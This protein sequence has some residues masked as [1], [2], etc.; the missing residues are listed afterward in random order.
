MAD[1]QTASA[2]W[3]SIVTQTPEHGSIVVTPSSITALDDRNT[4]TGNNNNSKNESASHVGKRLSGSIKDV[5]IQAVP[6]AGYVFAGWKNIEKDK[7]VSNSVTC[8]VRETEVA[9]YMPVFTE[10]NYQEINV[11]GSHS[12]VNSNPS[13]IRA[14]SEMLPP[15]SNDGPAWY[16]FDKSNGNP[17]TTTLWHE[18]YRDSAAAA[19]GT[20]AGSSSVWVEV[21]LSGNQKVKRVTVTPRSG[22]NY[23][24]RPKDYKILVANTTAETPADSD[25]VVAA[26]GTFADNTNEKTI[27]LPVAVQPSH[28]RIAI[29]SLYKYNNNYMAIANIGLYE[30][31]AD[32]STGA[33][34]IAIQAPTVNDVDM[35]SVSISKDKLLEGIDTDV[36][37]TATPKA[38]YRFVKWIVNDQ[39]GKGVSEITDATAT[40]TMN[41]KDDASY[42]AIF[43]KD[44]EVSISLDSTYLEMT[45]KNEGTVSQTLTATLGNAGENTAVTWESSNQQVATVANGVVTAVGEGEAT[46]TATAAADTT[47]SATCTVV[48]HAAPSLETLKALLAQADTA[49]DAVTSYSAESRES[50]RTKKDSIEA[51][52]PSEQDAIT[53]A[54]EELRTALEGLVEIYKISVPNDDNIVLD[55]DEK[56]DV[57]SNATSDNTSKWIYTPLFAKVSLSVKNAMTDSGV[58]AGWVYE[59]KTVSTSTSYKFYV[60]GDMELSVTY[61]KPAKKEV[62]LFCTSKYSTSAGK[63]SFIGKRSVPSDY[64]VVE[65]GIVITDETGWAKYENNQSAFVKGATRTKKSVATGKANN[66]T[67]EA[68]LKCGKNEKWYGRSYVT[69]SD[70]HT[71]YTVYSEI[72]NYPH[73]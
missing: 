48:V 16:A 23:V 35:G 70:G 46:I 10:A 41:G 13:N 19:L 18:K 50:L 5:R 2:Q 32:T 6:D 28:I 45:L 43:A 53:A 69:Y 61:T 66:G 58:F 63:L 56:E 11:L 26:S 20:T 27:E 36:T 71:T 8:L 54:E 7:I 39:S 4:D 55:S 64:K 29:Y 24:T 42:Q 9:N 72:E 37:L 15:N 68:K 12:D 59:S 67:Y 33:K 73:N 31:T 52:M 30:N 34:V 49:V 57:G 40:V 25:F 51:N 3:D 38:G 21:K 62:N 47:K 14:S 44:A 1:L 22:A 60:I 65:H 17:N